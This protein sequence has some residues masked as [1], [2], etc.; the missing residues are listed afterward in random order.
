M[1]EK[2]FKGITLGQ[3]E[4]A[5]YHAVLCP[6]KETLK[7]EYP[8]KAFAIEYDEFEGADLFYGADLE[9]ALQ[10]AFLNQLEHF[11]PEPDEW[12]SVSIKG[13]PVKEYDLLPGTPHNLEKDAW[14]MLS[15]MLGVFSENPGYRNHYVV[16][17]SSLAG[18][19]LVELGLC[20]KGTRFGDVVYWATEA[21]TSLAL[22]TLPQFR[23]HSFHN[24]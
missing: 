8:A 1:N 10:R 23:K 5:R 3:A 21:G 15:H 13:T 11:S 22:G 18:E 17:E 4:R 16:S 19:Q 7:K 14:G 12:L 2:Q 20:T 6:V 24:H 9:D